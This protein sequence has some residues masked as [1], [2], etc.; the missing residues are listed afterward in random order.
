MGRCFL[1]GIALFCQLV[2]APLVWA[3][4]PEGDC[5]NGCNG[6]M[7]ACLSSCRPPDACLAECAGNPALTDEEQARC[8]GLCEADVQLCFELCT[9]EN[10]SCLAQCADGPAI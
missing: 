5:A 8:L 4:S 1:C 3:G 9:A 7:G 10:E 6:A 2:L